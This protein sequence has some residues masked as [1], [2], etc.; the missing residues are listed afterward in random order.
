MP[1]KKSTPHPDPADPP[2]RRANKRKGKG[3]YEN[4][5]PPI[6]S[7]I[8]R[9]SHEVRYWVLEH[10]DKATTRIIVEGNVPPKS[11]ILYTDEASNY[12]EVPPRH[13]SVCH[14]IKEWARDDDDDG[15]R[16]VHCNS[17]EGAGTSLRTFLRTFR[18][19]HKYY[20]A[21][22]VATYETMAN[23]KHITSAVIRRMC[24]G[25]MMH[26]KTS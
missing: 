15:I 25:N 24:F 19:V 1:G 14:S 13:A 12:P 7:L 8:S 17:C 23:A 16:E 18:G 10:A 4:D 5:R 3:T 11:T 6:L 20:L 26:T 9:T 21:D 2:R 22:Y